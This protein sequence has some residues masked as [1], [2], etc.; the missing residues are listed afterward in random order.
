MLIAA[1][2]ANG[3][4]GPSASANGPGANQ[5]WARRV[6][7][8]PWTWITL[9][10]TAIYAAC[11]WWMYSS[12]MRDTVLEEGVIPG[13][14]PSAIRRSAHLALPTLLAWVAVFVLLDRFRPMRALLWWL[15]LGWGRRS[16]RRPR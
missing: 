15:A 2:R 5:H 16:R 3:I 9:G 14:N 6:L 7:M 4:P 8:S 10:L 11:L 1:R 12:A 13:L